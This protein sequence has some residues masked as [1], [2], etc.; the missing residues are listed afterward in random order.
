MMLTVKCKQCS[1][2]FKIK[3]SRV[4]RGWGKYCSNRCKHLAL[5]SGKLTHCLMC[6]KL[7][8]RSPKE[9]ERSKS[10]KFFCGKHCQT[11]WRNTKIYIGK[12]HVNW[13]NG[14]SSYRDILNRSRLVKVC[15]RCKTDDARILLV[16]HKDKN[17]Q[18]NDL[19]NLTWLCYNCHFLI[20]HYPSE[21]LKPNTSK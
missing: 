7:I 5:R 16:H 3:P 11:I 4:A 19:S 1:T 6:H 14:E 18:N 20:H 17:C 13:R 9:L 8:Y 15:A 10:G 21:A 2:E 12:Y